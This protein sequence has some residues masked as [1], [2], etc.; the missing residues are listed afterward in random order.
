MRKKVGLG[1]L[2]KGTATGGPASKV[3]CC[4]AKHLTECSSDRQQPW[5]RRKQ[6]PRPLCLFCDQ[7]A[8]ERLGNASLKWF[9]DLGRGL[10]G[11]LCKFLCLRGDRLELLV[12]MRG[13]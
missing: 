7:L 9:D 10:L 5:R 13:R 6:N 2:T 8:I 1:L 11:V 4:W 3:D 12:R